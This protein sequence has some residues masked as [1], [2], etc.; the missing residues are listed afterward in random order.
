M[1]IATQVA[2]EALG[3]W[4]P[5][6]ASVAISESAQP[7]PR[8]ILDN[9]ASDLEEGWDAVV[10]GRSASEAVK[11]VDDGWVVGSLNRAGLASIMPPFL[12]DREM[13]TGILSDRSK[14]DWI[15]PIEAVVVGGGKVRIRS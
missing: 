10:S 5:T 7:P 13:L 1:A 12:I 4:P 14:D 15:D 2:K 11:E 6:V 3:K 9:M 8:E